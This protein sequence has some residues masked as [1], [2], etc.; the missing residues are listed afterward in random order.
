MSGDDGTDLAL[1]YLLHVCVGD[2][3]HILSYQ[4]LNATTSRY[5]GTSIAYSALK[6]PG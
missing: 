2:Y 4:A 3:G 1:E 6:A 5:P